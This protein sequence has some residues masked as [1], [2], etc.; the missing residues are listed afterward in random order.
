MYNCWKGEKPYEPECIDYNLPYEISQGTV[1]MLPIKDQLE[2]LIPHGFVP[3]VLEG[4][5]L[6]LQY[7]G[8]NQKGKSWMVTQEAPVGVD[9]TPRFPMQEHQ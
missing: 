7:H 5:E 9:T 8:F 6:A 4:E 2:F 1:A 3:I